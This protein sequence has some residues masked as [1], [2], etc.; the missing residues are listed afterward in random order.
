MKLTNTLVSLTQ[1]F[2]VSAQSLINRI[3][4]YTL[5][6]LMAIELAH[7]YGMQSSN[8]TTSVSEH[9]LFLA[10]GGLQLLHVLI[11]FT[12]I[13]KQFYPRLTPFLSIVF[14]VF[15]ITSGIYISGRLMSPLVSLYS[16]YIVIMSLTLDKILMRFTAISCVLSYAV[17]TYVRDPQMEIMYSIFIHSAV[18]VLGAMALMFLR[19]KVEATFAAL[20][21]D[22][23]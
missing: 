13:K 3:R 8:S 15:I 4:L 17:V 22:Y 2:S 18:L 12:L 14:D 23:E 9:R 21:G 6:S 5:L 19:N 20:L 10:L 1:V 11:I 16:L 7:Y